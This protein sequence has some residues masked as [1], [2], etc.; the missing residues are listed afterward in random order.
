MSR[1]IKGVVF[2]LDGTLIDSAPD[3]HASINEVL[4]EAGRPAISL[5]AAT[6][7]I[8]DGMAMLIERAFAATGAAPRPDQA[9]ALMD[10]FLRAYRNPGRPHLTSVYPG[11]ARV[12]DQLRADGQRLCV[13]TNKVEQA[14]VEV[15]EELGLAAKLDA[16]VGADT[17][18]AR[19]PDPAHVLAALAR[20][21]VQPGQAV[22]VGDGPNDAV[23]G[24]AAGLPVILVRYGYSRRP[25][26][27]LGADR[28]IDGFEELPAALGSL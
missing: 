19:K 3:L 23:A 21:G 4:T 27:E 6:E 8:G 5:S 1:I 25:V 13:C 12:L 7:M 28:L 15:L 17:V 18:P 24:R 20:I 16:I 9:P 22:M 14:A 26:Q 2:D 10:R 11:V